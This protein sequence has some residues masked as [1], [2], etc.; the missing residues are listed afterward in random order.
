MAFLKVTSSRVISSFTYRSPPTYKSLA[1]VTIPVKVER[2]ET[3]SELRV[4]TLVSEELVTPVPNVVDVKTSVPFILYDL[5]EV[6]SQFSLDLREVDEL[7][8][9]IVF[10]IAAEPIPIPPPSSKIFVPTV[11]AIPT[12]LFEN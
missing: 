12:Q 6:R 7:F 10:R 3:F 4:P 5:P 9:R 1:V 11:V 2:P 8:Q